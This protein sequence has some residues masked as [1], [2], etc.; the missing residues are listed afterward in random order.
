MET[1]HL[2][3]TFLLLLG[4][5][6]TL[7]Q[8]FENAQ[9]EERLIFK[10]VKSE[11]VEKIGSSNEGKLVQNIK[12]QVVERLDFKTHWKTINADDALVKFYSFKPVN[13]ML[14]FLNI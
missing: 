9:I 12:P 14:Q 4:L 3:H 1:Q 8:P 2:S 5:A 7:A 10:R 13:Y 6:I 11:D